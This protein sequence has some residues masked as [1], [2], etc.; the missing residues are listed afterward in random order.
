MNWCIY[1]CKQFLRKKIQTLLCMYAFLI[2]LMFVLN[3]IFILN[4]KRNPSV[5][6]PLKEQKSLI[7][8]ELTRWTLLFMTL[9]GS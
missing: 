2:N 4:L 8:T 7:T 1:C 9:G 3:L 5:L 6:W